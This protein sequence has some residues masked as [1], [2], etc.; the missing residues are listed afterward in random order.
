MGLGAGKREGELGGDGG[1]GGG[2]THHISTGRDVPTKGI[3]F[4][5]SL[6]KVG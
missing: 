1:G 2:G 5:E 3:L 6:W 4:S